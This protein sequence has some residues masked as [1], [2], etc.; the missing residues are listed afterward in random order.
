M[1]E[2]VRGARDND[3]PS[4]RQRAVELEGVLEGHNHKQCRPLKRHTGRQPV[5]AVQ[6]RE[7]NPAVL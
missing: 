7:R 5:Q 3:E 4:V 2:R 6:H 1:N